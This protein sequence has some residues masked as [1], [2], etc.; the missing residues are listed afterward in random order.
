MNVNAEHDDT[1]T[2]S[3]NKR[4]HMTNAIKTIPRRFHPANDNDSNKAPV[5]VRRRQAR[6]PLS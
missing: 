1:T 5:T 4:L 3:S 6:S 2:T